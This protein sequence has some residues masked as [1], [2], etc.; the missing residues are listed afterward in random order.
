MQTETQ[1][2][3]TRIDGRSTSVPVAERFWSCVDRS[4]TGCWEWHGRRDE[5]G[6]GRTSVGGRHNYGAHRVAWELTHGSTTLHVLHRCDN[7]PCCNPD[8]LFLGTNRDN[9]IDRHAKGRS[10]NLG[11]GALH[12]MAKLTAAEVAEMRALRANGWT[13]IRLAQRFGIS[14]GNVSKIVNGRSY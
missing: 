7:P 1:I 13:Q 6:Y 8:H 10:K 5:N 9:A 3:R 14:R 12:P 2:V 4:G 11:R